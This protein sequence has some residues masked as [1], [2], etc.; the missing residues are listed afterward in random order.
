MS[1]LIDYREIGIT[2]SGKLSY[3]DFNNGNIGTTH[4]PNEWSSYHD[5]LHLTHDDWRVF[6]AGI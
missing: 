3:D 6:G 1:I 5:Q 2:F 4:I